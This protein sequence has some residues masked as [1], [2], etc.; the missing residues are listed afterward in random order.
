M[1]TASRPADAI[2]QFDDFLAREVPQI[3]TRPRSDENSVL[4]V[5]YDEGQDGGPGKA[6]ILRRRTHPVR[7]DRSIMH[8]ASTRISRTTTTCCA[9][10]RT[11]SDSA[12]PAPRRRRHRSPR[13]GTRGLGSAASAA[14]PLQRGVERLGDEHDVLVAEHQRRA[15]L[16]DVARAPGR[17]RRGRRAHASRWRRRRRAPGRAPSSRGRDQLDAGEHAAAA[18]VA[19]RLVAA[20]ARSPSAARS[21]GP[22]RRARSTSRSSSITSSTASAAAHA[23]GFPPNVLKNIVVSAKRSAS[24]RRVITAATGCPLPIGLPS[25]TTSGAMP[26]RG[27]R[28]QVLAGAA[29]ADLHLVGDPERARV[30]GPST[31]A[32]T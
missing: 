3:W 9:R 11:D 25:V 21:A 26:E 20:P 13:S 14:E 24:S 15:N 6:M 7:R 23:T 8:V 1:T 19:D 10:S 2:S 17:P 28:P 18:H 27:E 22:T 5:A 29:V 31:S 32:A 12:T 4:F 30:V 16:E